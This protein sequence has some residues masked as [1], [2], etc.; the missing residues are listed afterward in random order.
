MSSQV[1]YAGTYLADHPDGRTHDNVRRFLN[2]QRFTPRQRWPQVR[3]EVV[4][5]TRGDV[6]SGDAV[7]DKHHSRRIE[8]VR[9]QYSGNARGVRAGTGPVTCVS[10][11][12]ETDQFWLIACRRSAPDVDGKTKLAH[13]AKVLAQLAPRGIACRTV[14][15]DGWGAPTA[16]FKRLLTE[17]KTV[18]CPLKSNRLVDDSGG[19]QP[20]QPVGCLGRSAEEVERGKTVRVKGMPK[21]CRRNFS[22]YRCPPTG[23]T[24]P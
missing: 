22:A 3:P 15:L 24:T 20:D 7:R 8:L 5:S 16:L 9:R 1:N 4:L 17:G 14:L 19:Q 10:V 21:D 18:Y 11:N 12:P 13:V 6:L 2:T 23:R